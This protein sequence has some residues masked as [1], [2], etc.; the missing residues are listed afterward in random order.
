MAWCNVS[1]QPRAGRR[2]CWIARCR[3][4]K[5]LAWRLHRRLA[6]NRRRAAAL[7]GLR[8]RGLVSH[9][10]RRNEH[11]MYHLT[12]PSGTLP[13]GQAVDGRRRCI[14]VDRRSR[15]S[16][17]ANIAS[18]Q[19]NRSRRRP[20]EAVPSGRRSWPARWPAILGRRSPRKRASELAGRPAGYGAATGAARRPR[21]RSG[22]R[23]YCARPFGHAGPRLAVGGIFEPR[24]GGRPNA[25]AAM[26]AIRFAAARATPPVDGQRPTPPVDRRIPMAIRS[27]PSR[28]PASLLLRWSHVRFQITG[29]P[30][31]PRK[32][33]W[34]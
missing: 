33:A 31:P 20:L 13:S 27:A 30:R 6:R 19:T 10:W 12:R 34:K 7:N 4:T 15:A 24:T 8:G 5:G 28:S 25:T 23:T 1:V 11:L 2:S 29:T 18:R 9:R 17:P 16:A 26:C 32:R 22:A 14:R 21:D 3:R